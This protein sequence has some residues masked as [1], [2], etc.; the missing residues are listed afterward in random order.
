MNAESGQHHMWWRESQSVRLV[1]AAQRRCPTRAVCRVPAGGARRPRALFVPT[2]HEE[3]AFRALQSVLGA[4][5]CSLTWQ[6]LGWRGGW[7]PAAAAVLTGGGR[8]GSA[9]L[10]HPSLMMH[11]GRHAKPVEMPCC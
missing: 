7:L 3:C 8:L 6:R 11:S 5:W 4:I 1:N 10:T 2:T 9:T